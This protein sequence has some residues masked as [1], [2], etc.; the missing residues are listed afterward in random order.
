M[1]I[2]RH[3]GRFIEGKVMFDPKNVKIKIEAVSGRSGRLTSE[4]HYSDPFKAF[5]AFG[6][7]KADPMCTSA[8]LSLEM[9]HQKTEV[10]A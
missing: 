8:K 3:W 4:V 7:L 10:D 6:R 9:V 2:K 5:L 1:P